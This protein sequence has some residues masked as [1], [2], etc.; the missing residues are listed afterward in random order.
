[1]TFKLTWHL[2]V[3]KWEQVLYEGDLQHP[4]ERFVIFQTFDKSEK[5]LTNQKMMKTLTKRNSKTIRKTR[6]C[7]RQLWKHPKLKNYSR[8]LWPLRHWIRVMRKRMT[9]PTKRQCHFE[10]TLQSKDM[11]P[12]R[13]LSPCEK[14]LQ[15]LQMLNPLSV[16]IKLCHS[17]FLPLILE[18]H[19][20][21][22][23]C[24]SRNVANC[25]NM[26]SV[27]LGHCKRFWNS[28]FLLFI[29]GKTRLSPQC[30]QALLPLVFIL[31]PPFLFNC[32]QPLATDH[33]A[34]L[35]H[36]VKLL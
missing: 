17:L 6:Q 22:W 14:T 9:W 27:Q 25:Q 36:W 24:N 1:M 32:R 13:F 34:C 2:D 20:R 21:A 33:E 4:Q 10:N 16:S 35:M 18:W 26:L 5:E 31:A 7:Q 30:S 28:G 11:W 12:M 19:G 23:I 15:E 3:F 29:F 8:D